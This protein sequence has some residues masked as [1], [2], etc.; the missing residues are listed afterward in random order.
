[1]K[2][3]LLKD[4]GIYIIAE[5]NGRFEYLDKDEFDARFY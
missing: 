5:V 3:F 4:S 1:M 2:D